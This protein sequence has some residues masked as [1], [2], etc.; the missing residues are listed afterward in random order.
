MDIG[1]IL[2][3]IVFIIL[4]NMFGFYKV[5]PFGSKLYS[6]DFM[7]IMA[8]AFAICVLFYTFYKKHRIKKPMF[9]YVILGLLLLTVVE[10]VYTYLVF[11]QPI[12]Y[13]LKESFYYCVPVILYVAMSQFSEKLSVDSV[14]EIMVKVS[15]ISSTI[16]IVV[17]SIYTVFGINLLNAI[18]DIE[19]VR[20]GTVR[21]GIGGL[22]VY[23]AIIISVTKII[24]NSSSKYDYLNI[25]LGFIHVVFI[26]KTRTNV[27]YLTIVILIL[28]FNKIR[29]SKLVKKIIFFTLLCI[30]IIAFLNLDTI[31]MAVETFVK[32]DVSILARIEEIEYYFGQFLG[33]PLLGIGFLTG[34]KAVDNW[35]LIGGN[36]PLI[37]YY[38]ED[39]GYI[40][41]LNK[42]GVLGIIWFV[43]FFVT[44][45]KFIKN[46]AV[47]SQYCMNIFLYLIISS[48]SLNVM[49]P[50]RT[51]YIFIVLFMGE[52][53]ID[54]KRRTNRT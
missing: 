12:Y 45:F 40:G 27:V 35:Q 34:D 2:V 49:D 41:F 39:V 18:E 10:V 53:V 8:F 48:I 25:F 13:A 9:S 38:R 26:N 54:E 42:F 36:N 5:L 30:A 14:F 31:L 46:N 3:W 11:K 22:I 20:Y 24:N 21:F 6:L 16:A 15:I 43:Y 29:I 7:F 32:S 1:N 33:R 28:C 17:F 4:T 50:Q 19:Y 52:I 23:P 37:Y 51:M 47:W 44:Y